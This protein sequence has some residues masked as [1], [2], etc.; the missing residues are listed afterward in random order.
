[1]HKNTITFE[2]LENLITKW[3]ENR[4]IIQNTTPKAHFV[5]VAEEIGEKMKILPISKKYLIY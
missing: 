2:E 3:A 5:K 4:K 1:M